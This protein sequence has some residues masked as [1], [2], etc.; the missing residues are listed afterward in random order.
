MNLTQLAEKLR[1]KYD[2]YV[3][4]SLSQNDYRFWVVFILSS[5]VGCLIFYLY[6]FYSEDWFNVKGTLKLSIVM[7]AVTLFIPAIALRRLHIVA[8]I[9]VVRLI[10]D[11]LKI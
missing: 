6:T 8:I 3:E 5:I 11:L 10:I 9:I 4:G 2:N 7:A 1:I